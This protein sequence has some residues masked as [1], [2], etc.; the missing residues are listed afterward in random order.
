[1]NYFLHAFPL[2]S[3]EQNT[4]NEYTIDNI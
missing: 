1:M 4:Y 2:A 3:K